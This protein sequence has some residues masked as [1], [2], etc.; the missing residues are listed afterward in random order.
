MLFKTP[1]RKSC[2][3]KIE[4]LNIDVFLP[5][6]K[7]C[8]FYSTA[9][10]TIHLPLFPGYIFINISPGFR[11]HITAIPEVYKFIKFN[12]EYAKVS[13][14]EIKSL[15]LL[16]NKQEYFHGVFSKVIFEKG[17]NVEVVDG[18]FKGIKGQMIRKN[19]K[20]RIIV[21]INAIKESISFEIDLKFLRIIDCKSLVGIQG[22]V[23][24][25][26]VTNNITFF[27]ETIL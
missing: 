6:I 11:H 1:L 10:K 7:Q 9:T 14:E 27:Y 18:P 21:G 5:L 23:S 25:I 4:E 13:D 2:K 24:S 12:E 19:G 15:Q 3:K 17:K 16:V 22:F 20:R 26:F 8:K